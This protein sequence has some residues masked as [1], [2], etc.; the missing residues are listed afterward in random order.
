M[1]SRSI[2]SMLTDFTPKHVPAD[3]ITVFA[4]VS[5]ETAD[6]IV[7]HEESAERVD[8][9]IDYELQIKEAF[10]AGREAGQAEASVLFEAD[11]VRLEREFQEQLEAADTLFMEQTGARMATQISEGLATM[12]AEL[13]GSLAAVLA[14]LV[15]EKLREQAIT[16]F[17][18]EV[19]RLTKGL[20]GMV[21]DVT[22]PGH[23][24]ETLR[25]RPEIDPIRF[26]FTEA[27]RAELSLKLDDVVVETRLGRLIDAL[28][29]QNG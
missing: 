7:E 25:K 6:P 16:A 13:S 9:L 19:E 18:R 22:G 20:E 2:A 17:V 10:N 1:S 11:K 5:K 24:L 27:A 12:A 14:P 15:E 3:R 8:D 28:K 29:D 4:A 23:L 21:A 26:T